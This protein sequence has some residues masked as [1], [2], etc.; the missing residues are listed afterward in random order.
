M[1]PVSKSH[2]LQYLLVTNLFLAWSQRNNPFRQHLYLS[3][4]N[5]WKSWIPSPH[6]I[7]WIFILLAGKSLEEFS[8]HH[9]ALEDTL[10]NRLKS[11][12]N[13]RFQTM[14]SIITKFHGWSSN[15]V[16]ITNGSSL[17]PPPI[18]S[19]GVIIVFLFHSCIIS[20]HK[21]TILHITIAAL[22]TQVG[23]IPI[24]ILFTM[25]EYRIF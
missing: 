7:S 24:I 13:P 22:F 21:Y 6:V 8:I 2:T 9:S 14:Y 1:I 19:D 5:Q 12:Y 11:C 3:I 16:I 20:I 10:K 15:I 17:I 25:N 4:S 23:I 18:I